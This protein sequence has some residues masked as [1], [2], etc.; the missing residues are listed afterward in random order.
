MQTPQRAQQSRTTR[1]R[2]RN[3]GAV[4]TDRDDAGA[5]RVRRT[6]KLRAIRATTSITTTNSV[7]ATTTTTTTT[8]TGLPPLLHGILL[9]PP[10]REK[11][12]GTTRTD[13]QDRSPK[14]ELK[15]P[16]STGLARPPTVRLIAATNE[17]PPE[18]I[19]AAT[20]IRMC[21]SHDERLITACLQKHDSV[22]NVTLCWK[23]LRC[24]IEI[25]KNASPAAKQE[26]DLCW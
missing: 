15:P 19:A 3:D 12:P 6:E 26:N 20:I 11:G 17:T 8:D 24:S 14:Q 7:T 2:W 23:L 9:H 18:V 21:A 4:E 22:E 1:Q 5:G 13:L 16:D 10:H 25:C